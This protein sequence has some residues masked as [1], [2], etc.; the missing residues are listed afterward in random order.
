MSLRVTGGTVWN[1]TLP[2]PGSFQKPGLLFGFWS[3]GKGGIGE[4]C[5]FIKHLLWARHVSNI[6]W[7]KPFNSER[8]LWDL[9]LTEKVSSPK[10][11]KW[12]CQ[13]S[14]LDQADS[15]RGITEKKKDRGYQWVGARTS[16]L[17]EKRPE[18]YYIHHTPTCLWREKSKSS[19][20]LNAW[21]CP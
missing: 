15:F 9:R 19:H 4:T 20:H 7:L 8:I 14:K 17:S 16:R 21:T 1:P 11:F 2:V 10:V 13:D 12:W 5:H 6:L 3:W 18:Q